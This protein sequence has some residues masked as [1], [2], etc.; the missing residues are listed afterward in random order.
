MGYMDGHHT[1]ARAT[2]ICV[3]GSALTG[4]GAFALLGN[5][6]EPVGWAEIVT[7]GGIVSIVGA[8]GAWGMH[9]VLRGAPDTT[10]RA[11][12]SKPD[13]HATDDRLEAIRTLADQVDLVAL[14]AAIE[15]AHAGDNARGF[16]VVADE[17][18]RLAGRISET[19]EGDDASTRMDSARRG[20]AA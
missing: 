6:T 5:I 10:R 15:A 16:A 18:R 1:A 11:K 12:T 17:I 7:L 8:L 9:A 3:M 19:A 2:A 20:K 13:A 14:N 4:A